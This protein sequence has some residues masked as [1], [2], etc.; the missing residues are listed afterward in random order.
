VCEPF[1]ADDGQEGFLLWCECFE[2]LRHLRVLVAVVGGGGWRC[3]SPRLGC[4]DRRLPGAALRQV[5]AWGP[6][7][8]GVAAGS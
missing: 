3:R 1:V 2:F 8:R 7:A 4:G 5:A 6:A